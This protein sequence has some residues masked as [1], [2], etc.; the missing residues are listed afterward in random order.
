MQP[1]ADHLLDLARGQLAD[2]VAD[3][4]VGTA[5]RRLLRGSHLEDTVDVNFENDLQNRLTGAHRR[6]WC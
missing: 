4:D 3:G 6:D 2:R 5:A 1:T